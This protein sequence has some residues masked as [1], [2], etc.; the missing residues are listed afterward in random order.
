MVLSYPSRDS[1]LQHLNTKFMARNDK[2]YKFYFHKLH[3]SW[4]SDKTPP[5][6]SYQIHKQDPNIC[7]VKT[8][9]EYITRTEDGGFV[10]GLLKFD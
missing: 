2:S 4:R 8:L 6:V 5:T 1:S 9:D 3:K 10:M 7:V